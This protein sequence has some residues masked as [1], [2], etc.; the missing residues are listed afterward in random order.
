VHGSD[1]ESVY[2]VDQRSRVKS[3]IPRTMAESVSKRTNVRT[4]FLEGRDAF[5]TK[6]REDTEKKK[7]E[8][9][10]AKLA[11]R[12]E[13]DT[14]P[15]GTSVARMEKQKDAP[16]KYRG[17]LYPKAEAKNL[18]KANSNNSYRET[19]PYPN[20]DNK[21][22]E[23]TSQR[24]ARQPVPATISSPPAPPLAKKYSST[25]NLVSDVKPQKSERSTKQQRTEQQNEARRIRDGERARNNHREKLLKEAED[26]DY[27]ISEHEMNKRL[28]AYMKKR[29]VCLLHALLLV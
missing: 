15:K 10:K 3:P 6:K 27:T 19:S 2:D 11:A 20:F 28:D 23:S 24:Q 25:I 8:D 26:G 18:T 29:E 17:P 21:T 9:L 14:V 4:S 13:K 12:F 7:R 1:Y 16:R 22:K 5:Y